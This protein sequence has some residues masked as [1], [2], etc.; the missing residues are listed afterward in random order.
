MANTKPYNIRLPME[1]ITAIEMFAREKKVTSTTVIITAL[2]T[3]LINNKYVETPEL[4]VLIN[5]V[6]RESARNNT[7]QEMSKIMFLHNARKRVARM[8]RD[9]IYNKDKFKDLIKVWIKEAEANG[10]EAEVFLQEIKKG[11]GG[12]KYE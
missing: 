6:E 11:I 3:F 10:V 4:K 2:K 1:I 12:V 9:G 5:S 8:Y 7:K